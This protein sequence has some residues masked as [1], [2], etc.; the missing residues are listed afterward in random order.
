MATIVTR[1]GKG[2]K[3]TIE[4]MDANF[5]NLNTQGVNNAA[6][7]ENKVDQESGKG[8]SQ[9]NFSTTEKNKLNGIQAGAT[10]NSTDAYLLAL[11]NATGNLPA[12][13]VTPD[14][15]HRFATDT[16][17]ATWNGKQDALGY[18][19]INSA[20][21]GAPNGVPNLGS[22]GRIPSSQVPLVSLTKPNVVGSQ[23]AMLALVAEEGDFAIRTDISKTFVLSSGS[24]TILGSWIELIGPAGI[25][26]VNGQSGPT[27]VLTTDNVNEGTKKYSS[28]ALVLSYLLNGFVAGT[29]NVALAA[30]D[31]IIQ[32]F[33][34]IAGSIADIYTQLTGKATPEDI[35]Q[36]LDDNTIYFSEATIG[37][38]EGEV[39][40]DWEPGDDPNN[41]PGKIANPLRGKGGSVAVAD[42]VQNGNLNPV[43]SNAVYNEL[44]D[45]LSLITGGSEYSIADLYDLI[46]NGGLA[47]EDP[48]TGFV[49][50][51][52]ADTADFTFADGGDV[53]GD[54]EYKL[55][56]ASIVTATVKPIIVG[57]SN[58]GIGTVKI[59]K[60]AETGVSSPSPWLVNP[61]A[62]TAVSGDGDYMAGYVPIALLSGLKS[63]DADTTITDG[64]VEQNENGDLNVVVPLHMPSGA[65]IAFKVLSV[66][67][68][69]EIGFGLVDSYALGVIRGGVSYENTLIK[70]Y[71]S[72]EVFEGVVVN[73]GDHLIL[74][75]NDP[76]NG[77]IDNGAVREFKFYKTSDGG[78]TITELPPPTPFN[79]I[80]GY[81]GY[82]SF[83]LIRNSTFGYPQQIGC[84][85]DTEV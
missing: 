28:V 64:I 24:P 73:V 43:T 59:R 26:T 8:L 60:K 14:A 35:E 13:Q 6:E 47:P 39:Y 2:T 46:N 68:L 63:G 7:L 85:L 77:E 20:E 54:Y 48:P 30:G 17:K 76:N 71:F 21:K 62:Y 36:A 38:F 65:R 55:G 33:N 49:V 78:A 41:A 79:Y 83:T 23:S 45:M 10:Q 42:I 66:A 53:I 37:G 16:E 11:P 31:S 18:T 4:E 51:D 5:T 75:F 52:E 19:P 57:N 25:S 72:D 15:T 34:K 9:E 61:T 32:A 12:A 3:L 82:V 56:A 50:D 67:S 44:Q 80:N 1:T 29:G 58:F 22:D 27:V 40:P 81:T 84:I 70:K 74:E 69:N